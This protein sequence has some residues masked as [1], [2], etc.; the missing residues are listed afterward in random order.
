MSRD[1]LLT[2]MAMELEEWPHT[3]Q[4][5]DELPKLPRGWYWNPSPSS[6]TPIVFPEDD[7]KQIRALH[8]FT[9]RAELIN[10]PSWDD[11]PEWAEWLAQDESGEWFWF[12]APVEMLSLIHI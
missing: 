1:E 4:S 10:R 3:G 11:A 6:G 9:R 8:Y 5:F 2:K 12:E 7:G